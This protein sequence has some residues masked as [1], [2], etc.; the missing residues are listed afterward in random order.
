MVRLAPRNERG[1][2][3]TR[4]QAFRDPEVLGRDLDRALDHPNQ[5]GVHA[6]SRSR[7]SLRRLKAI[8]RYP[9]RK[10][11]TPVLVEGGVAGGAL[12]MS[13]GTS[14]PGRRNPNGSAFHRRI[15]AGVQD[16]AKHAIRAM[17]PLRSW[18]VE[19]PQPNRKMLQ[20]VLVAVF[21]AVLLAT[22]LPSRPCLRPAW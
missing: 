11:T 17:S 1:L 21:A 7:D 6:C 9:I 19:K 18:L 12:P 2:A 22:R 4:A 20:A 10:V 16:A 5:V 15:M 8:R 3:L 13:A 14:F